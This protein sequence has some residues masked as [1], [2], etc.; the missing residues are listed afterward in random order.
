MFLNPHY[1]YISCTVQSHTPAQY[2]SNDT[3]Q[4]SPQSQPL[5]CV[6]GESWAKGT[7]AGKV[8]KDNVLYPRSPSSMV[9]PLPRCCWSVEPG[10]LVAAAPPIPTHT[11]ACS[12]SQ[13]TA[14]PRSDWINYF[15]TR[16][17]VPDMEK[18]F[19]QLFNSNEKFSET[20]AL[21]WGVMFHEY[22]QI[23]L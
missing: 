1:H 7:T 3:G 16:V 4:S 17:C 11:R 22:F 21:I 13:F 6:P 14:P 20:H 18:G 2:S 19:S 10:A 9:F 5:E 15:W 12:A 8:I 23:E